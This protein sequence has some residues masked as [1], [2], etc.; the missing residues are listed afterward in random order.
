[1][2]LCWL[3][4][5]YSSQCIIRRRAE[6]ISIIH[7]ECFE[8]YNKGKQQLNIGKFWRRYKS[9]NAVLDWL[10]LPLCFR[11]FQAAMLLGW[12]LRNVELFLGR[13]KHP[14]LYISTKTHANRQSDCNTG[15]ITGYAKL[16]PHQVILKQGIWIVKTTCYILLKTRHVYPLYYWF[17]LN[18]QKFCLQQL[19]R[20][21]DYVNIRISLQNYLI[22]KLLH[23]TLA[24]NGLANK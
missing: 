7:G 14:Y 6:D 10:M 4:L 9:M 19:L 11:T 1:M 5:Q 13:Y 16:W 3:L 12:R 22:I 2:L 15:V 17:S 24:G 23:K 18:T 21:Y 8:A 20:V